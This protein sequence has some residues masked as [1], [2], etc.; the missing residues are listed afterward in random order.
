MEPVSRLKRDEAMAA[1]SLGDDEVRFMVSNYY[2][3][4]DNR[5][6]NNNQ[7]R[8][9]QESGEPNLLLSWL[10][11]Q[12]STLEQQVK[13]ALDKYTQNHKVGTWMRSHLGIGPVISAGILAHI[14]IHKAP[15]AGHIW[16][17]AGLVDG[18][19]WEKGQKRPWNAELKK[20]CFLLGESFVKVSGKE[21]AFYGKIYAE[22][23]KM[24]TE[25]N[26]RFEYKDQA[27]RIL[28]T[29]NIGNDTDAYKAYIQGKLPPAHIH[30]RACRYA[31]KFFLSHLH[32][33]WY[34]IEF[35]RDPPKP[36]VIEH[37]GHAHVIRPP[38]FDL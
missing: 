6:R 14:D 28:A 23:K 4:Q 38:N 29:K 13:R 9:T 7:V 30:R 22:R 5:I 19:K 32:H 1:I 2:Q 31:T 11:E 17:Y 8:A 20:L 10:A 12:N 21:D 25:K 35:D 37:L 15:T 18:V 34:R 24:E 3:M 26:E 36:F 16:S 27:A 33:A